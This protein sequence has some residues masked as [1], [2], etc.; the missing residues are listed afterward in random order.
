M[1]IWDKPLYAII[2]LSVISN[3]YLSHKWSTLVDKA[4]IAGYK[5]GVVDMTQIV[6]GE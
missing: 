5:H 2:C 3:L 6:T 1:T 4:Y